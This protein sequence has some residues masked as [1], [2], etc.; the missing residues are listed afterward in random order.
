M[1]YNNIGTIKLHYRLSQIWMAKN[2]KKSVI[3]IRILYNVIE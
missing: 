3:A 2:E 1:S